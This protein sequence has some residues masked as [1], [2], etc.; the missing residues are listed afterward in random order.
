MSFSNLAGK[1]QL[2]SV[3]CAV[4][5]V[6]VLH[7]MFI[8]STPVLKC[9]HDKTAQLVARLRLAFY[10]GVRRFDSGGPGHSFNSCRILVIG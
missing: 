4:K 7:I 1:T 8:V 5:D 10:S 2:L 3:T 6:T 9:L